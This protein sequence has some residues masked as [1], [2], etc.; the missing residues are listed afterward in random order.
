MKF[1]A[2]ATATTF[3][4]ANTKVIAAEKATCK[5]FSIGLNNKE[6]CDSVNNAPHCNN[7]LGR[8][9]WGP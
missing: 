1:W 2:L 3:V 6:L 7:Q 9:E 8:C 5:C 4:T